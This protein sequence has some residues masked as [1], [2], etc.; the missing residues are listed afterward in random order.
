[1]NNKIK[2]LTL[3]IFS[4]ISVLKAQSDTLFY[5]GSYS[6][7][8]DSIEIKGNET[9]KDFIILRELTIGKGD[10]LNKKLANYNRERIYSL[11]IFNDVKLK[12]YLYKNINTLRIEIE[13]SWYIYP[14]PFITLKDKDWDKLSYG[15]A[16]TLK[17][18]RGR[19]EDLKGVLALGYDPSFSFSYFNPNLSYNQNLRLETSFRYTDF[20]NKS[21]T[22]ETIYGSNFE[23][24]IFS[25]RLS[26]GKRF[27]NFH[28]L[29]LTTG[30]DYIETPFYARGINA[31]NDRIDR[32]VIVGASYVY[33]TRDLAQYPKNGIFTFVNLEFK[34]L[35]SNNINYRVANLE[36]REYRS[37]FEKLTAKWRLAF[38]HTGGGLVPYYDYSYL[39]YSER[40]RGHFHGDK[41][42]GNDRFIGSVELNYPIIEETRINL[43]F[44]PLLPRSLLSYRVAVIAQLFGDT[45][46]AHDSGESISI[47]KFDTGYGGGISVLLLPY[48]IFRL[49]LAF[50]EQGKTEW[51]LDVGASF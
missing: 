5:T 23:Q 6:I 9:T 39:G 1:M 8:V 26:F 36:F 48:A 28:L 18:F 4:I 15:I 40:V 16:V 38:R 7:V 13:E 32:T 31:S 22:A 24:K 41:R 14:I 50:N 3:L 49:E 2:L 20:T 25:S 17:N 34:G 19:N 45:G 46:T 33:D 12:P 27:G 47:N 10:T 29:T 21:K 30:Y 42:E 35:G 37:F 44:I 11:N 51:I 43:Y